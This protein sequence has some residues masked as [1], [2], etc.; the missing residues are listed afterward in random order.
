MQPTAGA[1]EVAA[2]NAEA[3]GGSDG[4]SAATVLEDTPLAV[5]EQV[6]YLGYTQKSGLTHGAQGEVVEAVADD[7]RLSVRFPDLDPIRISFMSLSRKPAPPLPGEFQ[8]GERVFCLGCSCSRDG[9][10]HGQRGEVVGL[11]APDVKAEHPDFT[12]P[13]SDAVYVWLDGGLG[14]PTRILLTSLSRE[15]PPPLVGGFQLGS[16]RTTAGCTLS[17][18]H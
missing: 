16:D 11:A 13:C 14:R 5:G 2:S 7:G 10:M 18:G 8:L 17:C 1:A 4:E 12:Q 3:D 6:H 15:P 9:I